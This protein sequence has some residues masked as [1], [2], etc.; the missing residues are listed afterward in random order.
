MKTVRQWM[1]HVP[2]GVATRWRNNIIS[3]R[4]DEVYASISRDTKEIELR[5]FIIAYL[6]WAD[7]HEG[8]G[9]WDNLYFQSHHS[10]NLIDPW[11]GRDVEVNIEQKSKWS[12]TKFELE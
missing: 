5:H 7:S 9:Y 6:D 8:T 1:D 10:E 2:I 3:Q 4:G 11:A 12:I